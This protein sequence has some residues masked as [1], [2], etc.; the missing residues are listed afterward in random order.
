MDLIKLCNLQNEINTNLNMKLIQ[1]MS[2]TIGTLD[3]SLSQPRF[4]LIR[5]STI[6]IINYHHLLHLL[7]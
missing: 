3:M 5:K 1:L 4:H 7:L 6:I 2:N